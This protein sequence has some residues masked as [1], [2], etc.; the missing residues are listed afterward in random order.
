MS[1]DKCGMCQMDVGDDC[2]GCDKCTVWYH[3]TSTCVGLPDNVIKTI[4]D[5]GGRGVS[6]CSTACRLD[7]SGDSSGDNTAASLPGGS[8]DLADREQG[9][10]FTVLGGTVVPPKG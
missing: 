7:D 1:S 5:Y 10:N 2:I 3:P 6:F 8:Q 9:R 4:R